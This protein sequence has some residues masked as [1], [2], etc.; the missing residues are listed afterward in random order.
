MPVT[1]QCPNPDCGASYSVADE[2]V[3]RMGRCKRCGTKF[4]L[5]PHTRDH[6]PN[7]ATT[8]SGSDDLDWN[9]PE[10]A[11]LPGT[12]GRYRVL[13]RL[14]IG[15]MGSV[16]LALD[17]HLDRTVALKVPHPEQARRPE[18][19]E[20]FLREARAS[21][22]FQH[23]GFCP[24]YDI[25]EA[26]GTP[27]LAMAY[28]EGKTL[29]ESITPDQPWEAR[30][31]ARVIHE[32]AQALA[33][34][35]RLG[36]VHRDLKPSNVMVDLRGRLVLMDFGLAR[37]F[38]GS[39]ATVT[40]SGAI[41]GTP[42]YMPPEQADGDIRAIGP[43]SDVYSLGVI[44]Y[45]LLSGRRPFVGNTSR[46]LVQ[47]LTTEPE[48]PSSHHG[49]LDPELE[50]ICLKAMA[51]A[52]EKRYSS[53]DDFA[54]ALAGWLNGRATPKAVATVPTHPPAIPTLP[55]VATEPT[56]RLLD[57]PARARPPVAAK[58]KPAEP[59]PEPKREAALYTIAGSFA[60][61]GALIV[62][63]TFGGQSTPD[64]AQARVPT[65][66]PAPGKSPT[67]P[68]PPDI[69]V[70]TSDPEP[71]RGSASDSVDLTNSVGMKLRLIP[72][73]EFLMGAEPD[74]PGLS[75]EELPRHRVVIT[76]AFFM[77]VHEVTQD[78]YRQVMSMNPSW[79]SSTGGGKDVAWGHAS[80]RFPVENVSWHDAV[81]FCN[82]LSRQEKLDPCY[83]AQ[84]KRLEG[85]TGYRLPT[86]AEWEYA[87]R[88]GT[89]TPFNIGP[90]I[91]PSDAN[92]DGNYTYNQS[93]QGEYRRR[94]TPV[95]SF[96]ASDFGLYDMHG[97]VWEWCEDNYS[98]DY[99]EQSTLRDPPGS[100]AGS[101]KVT[102]GGSWYDYPGRCRSAGR[103]STSPTRASPYQGFRVVRVKPSG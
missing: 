17:T 65:A 52:V 33:E 3:G 97:N 31:A 89:S 21:A 7:E 85:G 53:M 71:G 96:A 12:I 47:I 49:L 86:E 100:S 72:A 60:V 10:D 81:A 44:L 87:C 22:R 63:F 95:G 2:V 98:R 61:A 69:P 101:L 84:G 14:G 50:T 18:S 66:K 28:I 29:A 73:G 48:P 5:V 82:A 57:R 36:V 80:D 39:D 62:W 42:A 11:A 70:V 41:L 16:Y 40:A 30:E 27:F 92:Y 75:S 13:R 23:A 74:E 25:G 6:H 99:Y 38:D 35:H 79:F 34:A 68:K 59:N 9:A 32:L 4:P 91:T 93:P 46:I 45:E 51:K 67:E 58:V 90:R 8:T 103:E 102:R 1:F 37:M 77:G 78:E 56:E 64:R 15:G 43:H 55:I 24:I 76:R 26:D 88:A 19:R 54:A 20:R 94:P 83:D